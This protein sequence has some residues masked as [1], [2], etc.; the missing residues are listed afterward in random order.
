MVEKGV[1]IAPAEGKLGILLVGL[2]AVSTT[3]VAGNTGCR[4]AGPTMVG[5]VGAIA[6]VTT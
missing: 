5:A 2:G 3:L 4:I 6:G 1:G